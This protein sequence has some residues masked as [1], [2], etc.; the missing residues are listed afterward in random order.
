[1]TS[2][3]TKNLHLPHYAASD[4]PDFLAEIN[5]AFT[6]LDTEIKNLQDRVKALEDKTKGDV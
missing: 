4:H 6:T 1:M 2:E 5:Q 3:T